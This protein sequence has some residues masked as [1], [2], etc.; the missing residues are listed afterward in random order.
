MTD[1]TPVTRQAVIHALAAALEPLPFVDAMWEGGAAAFQRLDK[2][3]DVDLYVVA[4]DDQVPETFRV[5]EDALASLS[6]I[7]HKYEPAWPPE[8][9]IAQAFYRLE[10][11]SEFLLVDLAVLKRSAPDKFLEPELHGQA[12]FAF[13]K[14]DSVQTPPL[15]MDAFVR[16]LFERRD[17]LV[18]RVALF[19]SFVSKELHRRNALGALEAYQRI[20]LDSLVQVLRMHYHPAHYT[21]NVRY[22]PFELPPDVVRRLEGLSY[23][24]SPDDLSEMC[25]KAV[26]WFRETAAAV[27]EA[28][29]RQRL[30]DAR[31]GADRRT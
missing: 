2:W 13:N 6:P 9:G 26:E 11:A 1:A 21:F 10:R 29:V 8:S 25:R 17:R 27:S 31:V 22:V 19:E 15:D 4:A 23:V 20:V 16:K 12:I 18:M 3:S 7:R 24:R 14:R 28:E 30:G 5:V